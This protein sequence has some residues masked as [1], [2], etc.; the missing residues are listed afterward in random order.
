MMNLSRVLAVMVISF[1]NILNGDC[2]ADFQQELEYAIRADLNGKTL[3]GQ[4]ELIYKN[5]SPKEINEMY[6]HLW[7]N[8]FSRR[9]SDYNEQLLRMLE[10]KLYFAEDKDLGGYTS[11]SLKDR[12]QKEIPFEYTNPSEQIVK[13][14]LL[15]PLASGETTT[16]YLDYELIF[17]KAFDRVGQSTP[18]M[19][20]NHWHPKPAVYDSA[21]WHPMEYLALGE[22]Y[23]EFAKFKIDLGIPDSL[24]IVASTMPEKSATGR[25]LMLAGKMI[26]YSIFLSD[27]FTV[28][29]D[30]H[31]LPNG[32]RK[33]IEVASSNDRAWKGAS[34]LTKDILDFYGKTIGSLPYDKVTIVQ[35]SSMLSSGMEYP[36][37]VVINSSKDAK[38]LEYY[39]AHEIA[40]Q[41]FYAALANNE[42]TEPYF[43]EGL[44]TYYT[45][46]YFL[47][48]YG[49]SYHEDF[50][51]TVFTGD[52]PVNFMRKAVHQNLCNHKHVNF[53]GSW[54][55]NG[56]VNYSFNSYA[57]A[58]Q[59]FHYLS[60]YL[61][62][63]NF[64][65]LMQ[66]FYRENKFTHV[67][68]KDLERHYRSGTEANLDWFFD[69]LMAGHIPDFELVKEKKKWK[70]NDHRPYNY[71]IPVTKEDGTFEF[72]EAKRE[73]TVLNLRRNDKFVI[74]QEGLTPDYIRKNNYSHKR[75]LKIKGPFQL[76]D[77]DERELF[78]LPVVGYNTSDGFQL[79]GLMH[80]FTFPN[81]KTQFH[82]QPSYGFQSQEVIGSASV[83][84][85]IRNGESN[86]SPME[87]SGSFKRYSYFRN[88]TFDLQYMRLGANLAIYLKP[89][90]NPLQLRRIMFS[91]LAIAEERA[92][93][94]S[95]TEIDIEQPVFTVQR[96]RYDAIG[97]NIL[98]PSHFWGELDF[99]NYESLQP[100]RFVKVS[101][102]YERAFKYKP[103]K[104]IKVR[105]WSAFFPINTQRDSRSTNSFFSKGSASLFQQ[106]YADYAY[107]GTFINRSNQNV[108]IR[109]NIMGYRGGGFRTPLP[110]SS[111]YGASNQ[112]AFS[113][114]IE[115]QLPF[116]KYLPLALFFDYGGFREV[117][118]DF[119]Y[120]YTGGV[121]IATFG[122]IFAI[123]IPLIHNQ[124]L[125][126][127]Y[128]SQG[129]NLFDKITFN[130]NLHKLR[131]KD[132]LNYVRT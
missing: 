20:M 96:V 105:F 56:I 115:G 74:D 32:T 75:P 104:S 113:A 59:A 78:M 126:D 13:A 76:N 48:T 65:S 28:E 45:D 62:L 95:S 110:S 12:N 87:L 82:V 106:G 91:S 3:T 124:E 50:F 7:M 43:D 15:E 101:L 117:G 112:M 90:S 10:S 80:N 92:N 79:G 68:F 55:E 41:Y 23:S 127:I 30:V 37:I 51:S 118:S 53:Q 17:P 9:P 116:P 111:L 40:H 22:F 24:T 47:H 70:I 128:N 46:R 129:F 33:T 120:V 102:A 125:S 103:A 4:V 49:K 60:R 16:F 52:S 121:K 109:D 108:G 99:T 21:G 8:A 38:E 35:G 86:Q 27:K 130:I 44:A 63:A 54:K 93:F 100:E 61:G 81:G 5:N 2:Q 69:D 25:Y 132:W 67:R 83:T 11:F 89:E 18:V 19:Y 72:Q 131:I 97:Y 58:G 84:H 29:E 39:L 71:P 114:N 64:D 1:L 77:Y 66:E 26:D 73:W 122:D 98:S 85:K 42:R 88:E 14:E 36:G 107:D 123:N 34:K 6:F 119:Q 94:L 57:R 31:T